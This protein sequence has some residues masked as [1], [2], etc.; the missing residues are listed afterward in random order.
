MNMADQG[1]PVVVVLME[2]AAQVRETTLQLLHVPEP[3]WLTW[4]PR[5][6]ANHLLWH[7]GHAL[8]LQDALTV[9]TLSGISE[10]PAGWAAIFGQGSNP[11]AI[12]DWPTD[13]HIRD[14]LS[15]QLERI[16]RM[17]FDHRQR[18]GQWAADDAIEREFSGART[19]LGRMIHGWHDEARHQG[20]MRLLLKMCSA[21]LNL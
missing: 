8:W 4:T 14:L 13:G 16:V 5:G 18:I 15:R 10:L 12:R 3:S 1:N 20:E 21:R 7:G 9:R 11:A 2:L 6:T 17:M 19:P